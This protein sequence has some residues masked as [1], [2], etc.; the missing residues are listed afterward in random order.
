MRAILLM[1]IMSFSLN[2]C[3]N[4]L[5]EGANDKRSSGTIGTQGLLTDWTA[6]D[7]KYESK[8]KFKDLN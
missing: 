2:A 5:Q 4:G 8:L 3:D 1:V 7:D 6:L